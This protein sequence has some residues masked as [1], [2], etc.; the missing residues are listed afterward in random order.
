MVALTLLV[1]TDLMLAGCSGRL[2]RICSYLLACSSMLL[3]Y[4]LTREDMGLSVGAECFAFIYCA[5]MWYPAMLTDTFAGIFVLPSILLPHIYVSIRTL[6]KYR[7]VSALFRRDGAWCWAEED[8]RSVYLSVTTVY[9]L[10]LIL[11]HYTEAPEYVC[12]IAAGAGLLLGIVIHRKAYTGRTMLLGKKKERRIQYIIT[13]DGQS[14][15]VLPEVDSNIVAKVYKKVQYY[16][17]TR[18]PYLS[19]GFSLTELAEALQ[20]NKLYISRAVNLYSGYNF[21]AYVNHYRVVY[22]IELMKQDPYLKVIE[23]TFMS[24]FHSVVTYNMAFRMFMDE[25][26]SDM[27]MRLR[28]SRPRTEVSR[29]AGPLQKDGVPPSSPDEGK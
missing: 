11:L 24:G 25:T 15:T 4:P 12:G 20:I 6:R 1:S 2:F 29:P 17:K 8:S 23:L 7:E 18:K 16:M 5:S 27:L 28:M 26:P 3:S 22:S 9:G 10:A 13:T 14:S 21:R 19:D